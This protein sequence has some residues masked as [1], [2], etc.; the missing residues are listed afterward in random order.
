M[1]YKHI[2]LL[3][4]FN[5]IHQAWKLCYINTSLFLV[6]LVKTKTSFVSFFKK[7]LIKVV[8]FPSIIIRIRKT[9]YKYTMNFIF[10]FNVIFLFHICIGQENLGESIF[11]ISFKQFVLLLKQ[12]NS[13][14]TV[15]CR[16]YW[17]S[18]LLIIDF[19]EFLLSVLC[20]QE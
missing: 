3:P 1:Q 16:F 20:N 2:F 7:Q 12:E 4:I 13:T 14:N 5:V 9:L 17:V 8:F 11:C 6:T 15:I 19:F 10:V 18:I